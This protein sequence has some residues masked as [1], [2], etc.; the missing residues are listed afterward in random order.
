MANTD[1]TTRPREAPVARQCSY[2]EFMSCQPINFKGTEGA[3]LVSSAVCKE[4]NHVFPK[5]F[6]GIMA[7][8]GVSHY[9]AR[10]LRR[11]MEVFI[12]GLV[13]GMKW[14]DL[15]L[16]SVNCYKVAIRPR[17]QKQRP[18]TGIICS[19]DSYLPSLERKGIMQISAE[20]PPTTMPREEPTWG[21]Q[22]FIAQVMEKKLDDKRLEDIPV[23]REFPKVFPEDLPGLPP[24]WQVDFQI[25]L[26]PGTTP[27]ARAPYRLAPSNQEP[28]TQL[29][30]WQ[31]EFYPTKYFT[32]GAPVLFVIKKDDIP[33]V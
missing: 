19:S 27:V 33:E 15:A 7:N 9:D 13:P 16:L 30:E 29:Q 31:T 21:C 10:C 25:D 20:E 12:D 5:D 26:L 22:V 32:L 8:L 2:K 28:S 3:Y 1:N 6:L 14:T 23:V 24:I 11:I 18:A 4:L 17:S